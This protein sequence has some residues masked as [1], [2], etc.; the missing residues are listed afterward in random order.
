MKEDKSKIALVD[1]RR[2]VSLYLKKVSTWLTRTLENDNYTGK[3]E[4][5]LGKVNQQV[6]GIIEEFEENTLKLLDNT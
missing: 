6:K 1:D 3:E 2:R 4:N 5:L